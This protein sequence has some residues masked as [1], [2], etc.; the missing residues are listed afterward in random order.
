MKGQFVWHKPP[1]Q[2]LDCDADVERSADTA[3]IV[4]IG[5][6]EMNGFKEEDICEYLDIET[7]TYKRFS[8]VYRTKM[9]EAVRRIR[10]KQWDH[11]RQDLAQRIWMK[12]SLVRSNIMYQ[13]S[14]SMGDFPFM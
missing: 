6:A 12:S 8:N 10:K 13:H 14:M 4:F 11:Q 2:R 5:L 1:R 9:K 7:A 3:V